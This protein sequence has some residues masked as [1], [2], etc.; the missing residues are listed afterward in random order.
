MN[1]TCVSLL[2][3]L[4]EPPVLL[5]GPSSDLP[6]GAGLTRLHSHFLDLKMDSCKEEEEMGL[7]SQRKKMPQGRKPKRLV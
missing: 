2:Q 4:P 7:Q 1:G 5:P 3:E 6:V